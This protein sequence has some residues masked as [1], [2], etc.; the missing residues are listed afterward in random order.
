M[1]IFGKKTEDKKESV[2]TKKVE[3]TASKKSSKKASKDVVTS[4]ASAYGTIIAP[5]VT[6]K[7][8][9]AAG[10]GK[11]TFRVEKKATKS[12][13]KNVIEEMYSVHVE[14]INVIVVKPKRRTVK[15]DRGYQKLYKKAIVTVREGEHIAVFE[16]A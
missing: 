10:R 7:S 6:E 4:T 16:G 9:E 5:I 8:H 1:G 13:V 12:Q 2:S 3:K 11:Y 14:N 15:Y